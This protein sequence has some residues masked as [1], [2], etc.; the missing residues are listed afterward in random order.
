MGVSA[1]RAADR[2]SILP[3]L[4]LA[5]LLAGCLGGS[6]PAPVPEPAPASRATDA[7]V[8]AVLGGAF[9]PYHLEWRSDQ[10]PQHRNAEPSDDLPLDAPPHTWLPGFP[11]PGSFASYGPLDLTLP[12]DPAAETDAL[13]A[14]D[15]A[16]WSSV[17]VSTA[18]SVDFHYV[19]GTKVVGLVNFHQPP[20]AGNSTQ[21]EARAS[22]A[23]AGSW[24]GACPECLV[25]MVGTAA[26]EQAIDWV[27]RQPWIDVVTNSYGFNS[28]RSGTVAD[29]TFVYDGCDLGLQREAA[30]RGQATFWSASNGVD[31]GNV[32]PG[33][34]LL[35]GATLL[36]CQF[37]PDWVVTVGGTSPSGY[38]QNWAGRPADVAGP[39]EG[40]PVQGGPTIGGNGTMGGTSVATPV[41]AGTYARGLWAARQALAGESRVQADG[42]VAAGPPAACLAPATVCP[43]GD[44]VL[45]AAEMRRSYL[46][47]ASHT[48]QGTKAVSLVAAGP[49]TAEQEFLTEGH[50]TYWGRF[51]GDE[52]WQ[53][54]GAAILRLLLGGAPDPATPAGEDEWF[55]VD[56]YCRQAIWGEWA[57]GDYV[58]GETPLPP[59][60]PAWPA[61]TA[62][63]HSCP[64]LS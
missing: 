22:S 47:A 48:D 43:L 16:A 45:E 52:A 55:V 59:P 10:L 2:A 49:R 38:S 4:A 37:G 27:Y 30:G 20:V 21:H 24:F 53:A 25:V 50:G 58:A 5:A 28:L 17:A 39:T 23:A 51:N 29:R 26:D 11:D 7:V 31:A 33:L 54:E 18:S 15:S 9:N 12:L 36:S 1:G 64:L 3:S 57:F 35:P 14:A 34:A 41:N 13:I 8:V 60:D 19:P 42:V 40:Y 63:L 56:S 32:V 6:A 62:Y 61:R 46:D 44:G